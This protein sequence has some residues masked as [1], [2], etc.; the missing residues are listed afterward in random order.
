VMGARD[1][2]GESL[3]QTEFV[4]KTQAKQNENTALVVTKR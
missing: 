2:P 1:R 3:N 4:N